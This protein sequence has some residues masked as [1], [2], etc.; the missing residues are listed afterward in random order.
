MVLVLKAM[1]CIIF[2]FHTVTFGYLSSQVGLWGLHEKCSRIIC[3]C[4]VSSSLSFYGICMKRLFK[5]HIYVYTCAECPSRWRR[6]STVSFWAHTESHASGI[7]MNNQW[8]VSL[9][10]EPQ[11]KGWF[12]ERKRKLY[13]YARR[14]FN[15]RPQLTIK[16]KH[17]L[18]M[19]CTL[20]ICHSRAIN[21]T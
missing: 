20:M 11:W 12:L 21:F 6:F 10:P 3:A 4:S 19:R 14:V 7:C 9:S 15:M 2:I 18:D 13:C 8:M 5:Y 1:G 17:K 16:S